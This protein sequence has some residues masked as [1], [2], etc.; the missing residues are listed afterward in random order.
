ML[1]R[2]QV[3]DLPTVLT[4]KTR[5]LRPCAVV[6]RHEVWVRT[7]QVRDLPRISMAEP[8][9]RGILFSLRI[10]SLRLF[11]SFVSGEILRLNRT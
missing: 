10:A 1:K 2:G 4:S 7:R 5:G 6:D 9:R 8:S 3:S 11:L